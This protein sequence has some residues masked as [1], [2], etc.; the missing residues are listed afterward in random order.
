MGGVTA[1]ELARRRDGDWVT[2]AG[3]VIC[4]QRPATAKGFCFVT[5]ED[6]TGLA[7]VVITPKL[8]AANARLVRR[9]PLLLVRGVLQEE[10]GVLNIRGR[11]FAAPRP[12][13]TSEMPQRARL[14]EVEALLAR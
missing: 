13:G 11:R 3:L 2:V 10:Q 9:S 4:R 12:R 8:F 6:E 5:L 14:A 7:N 1:A